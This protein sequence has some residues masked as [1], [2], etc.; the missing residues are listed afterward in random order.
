MIIE[1][2]LPLVLGGALL[3]GGGEA[4]VAG[5]AGTARR[6]GLSPIVIGVL[7]IGFGTSTPELLTSIE[8]ARLGSPDIALGNVIGSNTANI[9]LI[10]GVA[11]LLAP[12]AL[13]REHYRFDLWVAVFVALTLGLA[14]LAGPLTPMLGALFLLSLAVYA[15]VALARGGTASDEPVEM[16]PVL[17]RSLLIAAGG[18]VAAL[19]G[20]RLFVEGAVELARMFSI[21]EAVIGATIVAVGTSLP[22]L[23]TS[24]MAA[25]R[26]H[27]EL[28]VGNIL[29]SNVFNILGVL[30]ATLM[31]GEI[32]PSAEAVWRD[33]PAMLAATAA[34]VFVIL[35]RGRMSRAG[36][37]ALI[38]GYA[39]YLALML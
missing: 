26:G 28:A 20:A 27:P 34:L 19:L 17:W 5:G 37:V 4:L 15:L 7:L 25:R 35:V 38:A 9:L 36:G 32:A 31:V 8:A 1:I 21:S 39:G 12:M 18:L 24:V 33:M 2:F 10:G 13:Q 22:E 29:G 3:A 23:A 11:A 30:G 14:M 16:R 6:L